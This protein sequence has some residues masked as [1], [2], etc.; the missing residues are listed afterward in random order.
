[1]SPFF[2][3]YPH[4]SA[5][6][7]RRT[8]KIDGGKYGKFTLNNASKVIDDYNFTRVAIFPDKIEV[9]IFERKGSRKVQKEH[10]FEG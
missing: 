5:R 7:F 6:H 1:M 9:E 2:W 4:P 3:P 10:S 8:G